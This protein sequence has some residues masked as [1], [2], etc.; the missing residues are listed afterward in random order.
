MGVSN[1]GKITQDGDQSE[2]IVSRHCDISIYFVENGHQICKSFIA[3]NQI[4]WASEGIVCLI[5]LPVWP[6]IVYQNAV[7]IWNSCAKSLCA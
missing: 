1:D 7:K 2:Y 6:R 3:K 5:I 4:P